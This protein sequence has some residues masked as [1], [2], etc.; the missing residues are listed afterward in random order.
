ME[1]EEIKRALNEFINQQWKY[2]N[3]PTTPEK[4]KDNT[5]KSPAK[6]TVNYG[7]TIRVKRIEDSK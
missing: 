1:L 6:K 7:K 5:K 3:S 4:E 2:I